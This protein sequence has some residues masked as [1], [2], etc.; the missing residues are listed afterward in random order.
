MG[1]DDTRYMF[2]ILLA[3]MTIFASVFMIVYLRRRK[4]QNG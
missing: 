3:G 1:R 2:Y 4:K